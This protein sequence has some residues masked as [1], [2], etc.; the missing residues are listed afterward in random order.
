V[1]ADVE[2]DRD[3]R[4]LALGLAVPDPLI[5]VGATVVGRAAAWLWCGG[6]GPAELDLSGRGSA[7]RFARPGVVVH[8]FR[9]DPV[10]VVPMRRGSVSGPA[11]T[12]GD[13]LRECRA[14]VGPSWQL[15]RQVIDV[16]GLTRVQLA[17]CLERMARARGVSSARRLLAE[18]PADDQSIR[19]PVTRYASNTPSTLRTEAIT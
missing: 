13:L 2:P 5:Q 15:A 12:A 1:A 6:P 14:P 7:R 19:L 18:L 10:D 11:R 16:T 4:E 8:A 3:Q 9:L 17:E